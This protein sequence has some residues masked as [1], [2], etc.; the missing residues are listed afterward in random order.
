MMILLKKLNKLKSQD[1]FNI[2]SCTV[3]KF[4]CIFTLKNNCFSLI[5][6]NFAGL[7]NKKI[8]LTQSSLI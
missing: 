8:K 4:L 6:Y 7:K 2:Y 3:N 5:F 1:D